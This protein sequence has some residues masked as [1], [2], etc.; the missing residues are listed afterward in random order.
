MAPGP[1]VHALI[2]CGDDD[3]EKEDQVALMTG[4]YKSGGD[5]KPPYTTSTVIMAVP[6]LIWNLLIS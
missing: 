5:G 6:Q 4:E 1:Q 3:D 2:Y